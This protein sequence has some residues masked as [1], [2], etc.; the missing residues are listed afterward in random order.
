MKKAAIVACSNAKDTQYSSQIA[1]L[2][3]YLQ[4]LGIEAVLEV[5]GPDMPIAKT[6]EIGHSHDSKAVIIG[7]ELQLGSDRSQ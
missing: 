4:S 2:T 3:T 7:R 6:C 5:C 1:D